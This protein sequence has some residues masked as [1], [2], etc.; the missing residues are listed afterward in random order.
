MLSRSCETSSLDG[1]CCN[2]T[3]L[4]ARFHSRARITKN[5]ACRLRAHQAQERYLQVGSAPGAIN[6][7]D[8]KQHLQ[9][10]SA[11][12]VALH[13]RKHTQTQ[14]PP[15]LGLGM[16]APASFPMSA[17]RGSKGFQETAQTGI[18]HA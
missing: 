9:I 11:W 1:T 5:T 15:S 17:V 2:T 6:Q 7:N 10:R 16:T 18:L 14:A 12:M 3:L 8:Q 4:L 13:F